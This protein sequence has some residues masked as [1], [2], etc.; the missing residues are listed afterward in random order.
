GARIPVQVRGVDLAPTLLH[1]AGVATP[2]GLDGRSLLPL[3]V[4]AKDSRIAIAAVGLN[5]YI[6]HL[7]Y[8]AV[9]SPDRLYIRERRSGSAEFYDLERDPGARRDLGVSHPEAQGY[10]RRLGPG[11]GDSAG[12]IVTPKTR[13]DEETRERLEALGYLDEAVD[14][15]RP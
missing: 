15:E 1:L 10:A 4:E 5:D 2:P 11:T 14:G 13:L 9:V 12:A 7:D 8:A 6:P 3:E